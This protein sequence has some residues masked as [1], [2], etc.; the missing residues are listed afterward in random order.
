MSVVGMI[1]LGTAQ[2]R[3]RHLLTPA[4]LAGPREFR[5]EIS[6]RLRNIEVVKSKT[7]DRSECTCISKWDYVGSSVG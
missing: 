5:S 1:L 4:S 2:Y 7:A 6:P 3:W